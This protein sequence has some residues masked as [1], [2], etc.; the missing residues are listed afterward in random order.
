M[1]RLTKPPAIR[2]HRMLLDES[3]PR[4]EGRVLRVTSQGWSV[5]TG[6]DDTIEHS[7]VLGRRELLLNTFTRPFRAVPGMAQH[8]SEFAQ[9]DDVT[10][11][12]VALRF[13]TISR[14]YNQLA[15]YLTGEMLLA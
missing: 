10:C 3:T 11:S 13:D 15:Q 6:I 2:N 12:A 14:L 7:Q 9:R 1:P 8:Y 5:V 4:F